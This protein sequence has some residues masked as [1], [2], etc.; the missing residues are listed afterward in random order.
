MEVILKQ[1]V[2]KLGYKD[3]IAKVKNGFALNFL[4]PRNLAV[5]ATETNLKIHK[6]NM[7]QA[8]QKIAKIKLSAQKAGEQLSAALLRVPAKA[9]E[10]GKIFGAVTPLQIA[11]AIRNSVGF[12]VDRR[13]I[14]IP[15]DIKDLGT[16]TA[17]V[18]LHKEVHIDVKFEVFAE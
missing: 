11:E 9:A 5:I 13:R 4:V 8:Q 14:K 10:T 1:D 2:E 3:D 18:D 6:E 12:E 7:K 15:K 16:Y 17:K